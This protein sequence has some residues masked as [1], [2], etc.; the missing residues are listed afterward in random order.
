MSKKFIFI[1]VII[2][3][4]LVFGIYQIFLKEKE[5]TFASEKVTRGTVV[6]EVSE[7]GIVKISEEAN[8]GFKTTGR[9]EEIYVEVGDI[10]ESGTALVKLET[11]DILI[12]LEEAQASLEYSQA[13]LAK[14]LAGASETEIALAQAQVSTTQTALENARQNLEDVKAEAEED[15]NQAYED[16]LNTLDDA[17]LK[18]YNAFNTADLIQR[19]YFRSNDQESIKVREKKSL[20]E[21][22]LTQAEYYITLAGNNSTNENIDAALSETKDSLDKTF[23]ALTVIRDTCDESIYKNTVSDTNKTSLDTEKTNINSARSDIID[24]QQ[25]ISSTKLTNQSNV[26]TAQASVSAAQRALE[27]AEKNLAKITAPPVQEDIDLD[28]AE[29]KKAQSAKVLLENKLKE[30]TLRSP[31]DGQIVKINK[32]VGETVQLTDSVITLIPSKPFEIE[33]DIYEEDIIRIKPGDPVDITLVAFPD[34]TFKG[35]VISIDPAEK[36]IEGVVYYKVSIGFEEEKEGLKLGMTADINIVT[37]IKENV[38]SIPESALIKKD[39]KTFVQVLKAGEIEER[40][41]QI[42]LEGSNNLIEVISGLEEGEEI[43]LQ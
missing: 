42:G 32:R 36:L 7:T 20:I 18:I 14:L 27:E 35:K 37:N 40:E 43:I 31:V 41:I 28:Q 4:V 19:T 21:E 15:L 3:A 8:L 24:S 39:K 5:E 10:V 23:D 12:Q 30:A 6:E 33:T 25:T 22:E 9:I 29:V 11:A 13:K 17:E 26:N 34:E 16:G 38:L 2:V 1:V